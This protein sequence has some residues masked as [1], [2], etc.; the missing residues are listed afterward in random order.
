MIYYSMEDDRELE[1]NLWPSDHLRVPEYQRVFELGD[2][3]FE[4]KTKSKPFKPPSLKVST[5]NPPRKYKTGW[6]G[7]DEYIKQCQNTEKRIL[8]IAN[9]QK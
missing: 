7:M 3:L 9:D 6:S 2:R 1:V 5:P 4:K 8:A